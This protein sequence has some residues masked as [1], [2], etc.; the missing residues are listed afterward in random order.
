ML[1]ANCPKATTTNAAH[2]FHVQP[3]V[4]TVDPPL[5]VDRCCNCGLERRY[6]L[7]QPAATPAGHGPY[8]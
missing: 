7:A 4:L 3:Y 5:Y 8:A 1:D 2:C 6:R